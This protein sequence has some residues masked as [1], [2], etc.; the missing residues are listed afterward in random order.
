M[1]IPSQELQQ[2]RFYSAEITFTRTQRKTTPCTEANTQTVVLEVARLAKHRPAWA[3]HCEAERGQ[4]RTN[5]NGHR[6]TF[7]PRKI[8]ALSLHD[9]WS[10]I[11]KSCFPP[12]VKW[13]FL[14]DEMFGGMCSCGGLVFCNFQ[15]TVSDNKKIGTAFAASKIHHT[16]R[17]MTRPDDQIQD[18]TFTK[19]EAN[20]KMK[21]VTDSQL[22]S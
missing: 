1:E 4:L 5:C 14:F 10:E 18:V 21:R 7:Y 19:A 16:T 12:T 3:V 9:L 2:K 11:E 22:H 15:T 20:Y 8:R 13:R 17:G 6:E